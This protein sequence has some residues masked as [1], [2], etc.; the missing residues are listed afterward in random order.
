MDPIS[1]TAQILSMLQQ[2]L[3]QLV[4]ALHSVTPE[5]RADEIVA[6]M[7]QSA[8]ELAGCAEAGVLTEE[9]LQLINE[10]IELVIR[11]QQTLAGR[12]R[13]WDK[14]AKEH[15][16]LIQRVEKDVDGLKRL[17]ISTSAEVELRLAVGQGNKS[18]ETK[19]DSSQSAHALVAQTKFKAAAEAAG[20]DPVLLA[21]AVGAMF[22]EIATHHPNGGPTLM[23]TNYNG[24]VTVHQHSPKADATKH[25]A[26]ARH[27]KEHRVAKDR[28]AVKIPRGKAP[29]KKVSTI[30]DDVI[31][32]LAECYLDAAYAP[33]MPGAWRD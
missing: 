10:K 16:K 3:P 7:R 30:P 27:P 13:F 33:P 23:V 31:N 20:V 14:W 18:E 9:R 8:R 21:G 26:S 1:A 11:G 2:T 12:K 19:S 25:K 17:A 32:N 4:T 15:R 22:E 6:K 29:P 5:G 28:H 24:P